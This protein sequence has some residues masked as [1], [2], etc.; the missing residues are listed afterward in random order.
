MNAI[1]VSFEDLRLAARTF[2]EQ[3]ALDLELVRLTDEPY[4]KFV[5]LIN[6]SIDW[7][8]GE[9]S[10]NKNHLHDLSEDQ[11]TVLVVISLQ[12]LSF[13]AYHG[14]NVGGST[15]IS[16]DGPNNTMW[17]GEAKKHTSYGKLFGGARQLID[18]Y[19]SGLPGQDRGALIIYTSKPNAL[20]TMKRWR[21]FLRR[22]VPGLVILEPAND[23]LDFYTE[24]RHAGS[25]RMLK[26]R[27][28]PAV[29]HHE[30]TDVLPEPKAGDVAALG[31]QGGK[32]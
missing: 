7:I 1:D 21:T 32:S 18:R 28:V 13:S 4:E 3:I 6:K 30:P 27:H 26:I 24:I 5:A 11:L 15:D 8:L 20:R 17:L 31:D 29:L 25:G 19:N 10:K 14:R 22:A 16:I 2:P 9:M 23:D 12:S